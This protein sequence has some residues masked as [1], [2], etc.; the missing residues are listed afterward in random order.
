VVTELIETH[1]LS[2][3]GRIIFGMALTRLG[4]CA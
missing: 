1:P 4:Y 3:T 2:A